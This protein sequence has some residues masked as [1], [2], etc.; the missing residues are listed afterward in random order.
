VTP[1]ARLITASVL[2]STGGTAIKGVS[3]DGWEVV[4]LRA[5][6]A[7]VAVFV[8]LPEARRRFDWRTLAVGV[9]YGATTTLFVLSNKLTTAANAVF[10][11]NTSPLF[12]LLL[13]PVV[14]R[15]R[16][17][18]DDLAFMGVLALG[19]LVFFTG[20][21]SRFATAP[22]PLLGNVLAV[23]S[24]ITWSVTIVGYRWLAAR[25][26]PIGSAAIAGNLLACA[27]ALAFA[28]PFGASRPAD[29]LLLGYLG[30]VQL[31]L[32]YRM[33]SRGLPHVR[34]LEAS[35]IL[36]MEPVLASIWAW[37]AFGETL[38]PAGVA[39]AVII[40]G[41]TLVHSIRSRPQPEAVPEA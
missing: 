40:L 27:A 8:L 16:V 29:W 19:M 25:G 17:S 21:E 30:V 33:V 14:L 12:I 26:L 5:A 13:A 32:A 6:V 35:L 37:L 20:I 4:A 41:A 38:G 11:Q 9:A 24:A 36:L 3:L 1:R 23:C 18:R 7:A 10:L 34:A 15:E 28:L 22:D 31:G 2:F 39:G